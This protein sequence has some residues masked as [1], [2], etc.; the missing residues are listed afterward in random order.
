MIQ[1]E[2]H[3]KYDLSDEDVSVEGTDASDD[4]ILADNQDPADEDIEDIEPKEDEKDSEELIVID[5]EPW[6]PDPFIPVVPNPKT[7]APEIPVPE[8]P[9]PVALASEGPPQGNTM[10]EDKIS[11][12]S[13]QVWL[14][15]IFVWRLLKYTAALNT[16]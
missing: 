1:D 16:D 4:D 8:A 2:N 5:D 6:A 10:T 7:R 15:T 13:T 14:K 12:S 9:A 11:Q 3:S